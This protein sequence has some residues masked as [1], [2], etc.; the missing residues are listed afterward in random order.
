VQ[1]KLQLFD[2]VFFIDHVLARDGI[3]FLEFELVWGALF[4]LI[5]GVEMTS[6]GGRNELDFVTHFKFSSLP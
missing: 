3:V 6:A 5:G 2:F 4:V 1:I